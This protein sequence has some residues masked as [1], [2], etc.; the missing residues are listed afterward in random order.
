MNTS[1]LDGENAPKVR[2]ALGVTHE[3]SQAELGKLFA[4]V[5]VKCNEND[6]KLHGFTG[7]W[8]ADGQQALPLG[9]ENVLFRAA[10][11]SAPSGYV[12]ALILFVGRDTTLMLN[13]NA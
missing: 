2:K 1:S 9:D 11:L 13:R 8:E 5:K 4:K 3:M 7:R 6:S 10:L 12:F